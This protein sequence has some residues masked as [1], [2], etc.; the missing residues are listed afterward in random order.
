MIQLEDLAETAEELR[1]CGYFAAIKGRRG[2]DWSVDRP[3]RG[4]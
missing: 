1:R 2:P 3:R 4:A